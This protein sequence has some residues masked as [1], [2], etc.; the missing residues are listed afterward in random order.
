MD[1]QQRNR[2][3]DL[4]L[5]AVTKDAAGGL[6]KGWTVFAAGVYAAVRHFSGQEKAATSA[7][8]ETAQ[9]RTEFD[10]NYRPGVTEAMRVRY[11]GKVYN[12][13]QVNDWMERHDRLVLTCDIGITYTGDT[14]G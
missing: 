6:V 3:I 11:A 4:E 14:H 13:R 10:I 9:A 5:H 7:G 1:S 2:L 12:V 8:G